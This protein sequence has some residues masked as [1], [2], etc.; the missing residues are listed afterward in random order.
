MTL[1][2]IEGAQPPAGRKLTCIKCGLVWTV[3][4]IPR[5]FIDP[6]RFDC[7]QCGTLD[8]LTPTVQARRYDPAIAEL[9]F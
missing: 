3:F 8:L 5:P 1:R 6:E 9:P 7:L 2:A 4:E